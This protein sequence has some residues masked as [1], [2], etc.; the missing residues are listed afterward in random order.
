MCG[1]CHTPLSPYTKFSQTPIACGRPALDY[2][3]DQIEELPELDQV[4]VVTNSRF[5]DHFK[6]WSRLRNPGNDR[7]MKM[8]IHNDGTHSNEDRLGG[9]EALQQM[10]C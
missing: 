7:K 1:V 3:M 8:I 6:K 2:L 4:H 9:I 5:Y 10:D